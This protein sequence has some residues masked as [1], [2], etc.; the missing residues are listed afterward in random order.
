MKTMIMT[1]GGTSGHVTPNIAL[2]PKLKEL[3]YRINY[4]GSLNG[5]EKQLI[6]NENI[7]YYSISAG[8]LR[9]YI[10]TKNIADAFRV[11]RGLRQSISIIK[12]VKPDILFSKGG[13]VSCPVVWA[14]WLCKVPVV[15]HESDITPGLANRLS[16]PFAKKICYTFPESKAYIPEDKGVMTGL[17][18]RQSLLE[19]DSDK[20]RKLCG[21]T[22]AKPI[23]LVIGGSQGAE[24][25][26]KEIR[27]QLQSLLKEFQI[28]HICGNGNIDTEFSGFEGYRQ[29]E[30]VDKD[31]A[32]LFAMSDLVISRAGATTL[33]EILALKKPNLLIPLSKKASRGDQILNAQSFSLQGFSMVLEEE[34]IHAELLISIKKLY[35]E[36]SNYI[37][38]MKKSTIVNSIDNVIDVIKSLN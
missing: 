13:F 6:K 37:T 33:F 36:K 2:M 19:G 24:A 20:G 29:Y 35:K 28:C 16:M 30:Y 15:I 34:Y 25:I 17:P 10:D 8:K 26:N 38:R 9:R 21:F 1:G 11:L 18:I 22:E 23:I 14:A 5:I 3:G 27:G 31:Q 32:H 12:K 4:I 7:P